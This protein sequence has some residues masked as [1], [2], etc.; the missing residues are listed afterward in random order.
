[1]TNNK[2]ADL[3]LKVGDKV[4]VANGKNFTEV[5]GVVVNFCEFYDNLY[6]FELTDI[7]GSLRNYKQFYDGGTVNKD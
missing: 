3:N 6:S 2:Q 7:N 1:M 5:R 4:V